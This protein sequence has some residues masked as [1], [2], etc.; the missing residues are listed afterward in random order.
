V[1]DQ[2]PVIDLPTCGFTKPFR[3]QRLLAQG[4]IVV[5]RRV[6]FFLVLTIGNLM[7]KQ[8]NAVAM[9]SLLLVTASTAMASTVPQSLRIALKDS[10]TDPSISHMSIVVDMQTIRQGRITLHAEN[11]SKSLVHEVVVVRDDSKTQLPFD[12]KA[13]RVVESRVHRVGEIADLGPGK[14]GEVT[15]ALKPGKY[16]LLCNEPGHYKDGMLATLTVTK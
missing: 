12:G 8:A 3:M 16:V 11:L 6:E 5:L 14:S 10:T 13:D 15:L 7:Q 1:V 9:L 2:A 4:F